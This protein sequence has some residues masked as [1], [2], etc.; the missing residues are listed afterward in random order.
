MA[1]LDLLKQEIQNAFPGEKPSEQ[2]LSSMAF[3]L[4]DFFI[5]A[6]KAYKTSKTEKSLRL[7]NL[8]HDKIFNI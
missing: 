4:I 2:E 6:A 5:M 1:D 3:E 7:F 8:I